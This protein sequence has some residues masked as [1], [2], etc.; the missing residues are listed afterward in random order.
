[1]HS[2]ITTI[3]A[4]AAMFVAPALGQNAT[5]SNSTD[6]ASLVDQLPQCA[7]GCLQQSA[8]SINCTSSDLP[9][10]CDK[11]DQLIAA[12]GPCVFTSSCNST[13][14]SGKSQLSPPPP[15]QFTGLLA[16]LSR[17]LTVHPCHCRA[18]QHR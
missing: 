6:L 12:I 5:A 13:E 2:T 16:G 3:L 7:L 18:L 10:L 11:S 9:C 17:W 15:L 1:M 8:A 4:T 14:Q